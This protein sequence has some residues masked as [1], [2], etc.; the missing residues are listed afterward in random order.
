HTV[1][2]LQ[3]ED[4]PAVL[5]MGAGVLR[6]PTETEL[7]KHLFHNPYFTADAVFALRSRP[8]SE[9]LAAGIFIENSAYADPKQVDPFM[10][11]FRLGAFGTEGM[12]T[13]R[14][15]GL[16]S[17]LAGE[18]RPVSPLALD[19]VGH[20]AFRLMKSDIGTFAA[21]VP[22]DVPHLVRFYQSHFQRQ[23]SF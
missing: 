19:L 14:I 16:F 6:V 1:T 3:R 17:F 12:T 13:K 22:S 9:P 8:D 5:R 11:C 7:E 23:G 4:L 10:P 20:A 18:D 2:P 15:N 21:Q